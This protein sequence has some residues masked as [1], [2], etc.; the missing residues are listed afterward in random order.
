MIDIADG[1]LSGLLVEDIAIF[2]IAFL[3]SMATT[4]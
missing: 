4:K 2:I 3:S 1:S